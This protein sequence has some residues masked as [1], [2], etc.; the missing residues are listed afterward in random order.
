[1]KRFVTLLLCFNI[2]TV[3]SQDVKTF[4]IL[5]PLDMPSEHYGTCSY[6]ALGLSDGNFVFTQSYYTS[7]ANGANSKDIG[8]TF[9]K[10]SPQAEVIDTLFYEF[11]NNKSIDYPNNKLI[12]NPYNENENI[13]TYFSY[14]DTCYYNAVFFDNDLNITDEVR[15][16]FL[17]E[18]FGKG[19]LSGLN[20]D[21]NFL[22][23]WSVS[24]AEHW[25]LE[26]DIY[27]EVKKRSPKLIV[28]DDYGGFVNF[29]SF[30]T[31]DE[32]NKQ[33]G[34][35]NDEIDDYGMEHELYIILDENLNI[36]Y[37]KSLSGYEGYQYF[38]HY[39]SVAKLDDG[40]FVVMGV[41]RHGPEEDAL[42]LCKVD[43]DFNIIET[44]ILRLESNTEQKFLR[45]DVEA[46]NLVRCKDGG[47]YCI[48]S[49]SR[50]H[51]FQERD[52]YVARVDKDLNIMWDRCVKTG[53]KAFGELK[54]ADVLEN[55]ALVLTG[56]VMGYDNPTIDGVQLKTS[57][58]ILHDNGTS[59]SEN[60]YDIR[61]Y[62]FYPN[63]VRDKINIRFSPDVNCKKIDVYSMDGRLCH[64]QNFNMQT[65][66]IDNLNSGIYVMNITL[67]NGT[68][69][70]DRIVVY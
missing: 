18:G 60:I 7:D 22:Y 51:I 25:A 42:R 59:V 50:H 11:E 34:F 30:F 49:E 55:G 68:T 45:V 37:D 3:F 32:E 21:N 41:F 38:C 64:T 48:W 9:V 16:P 40:N 15:K 19:H 52:V 20:K 66:N 31:Y 61:P 43:K 26:A 69:Y 4:D 70:T 24:A 57:V 65:I 8:V 36:A 12:R 46:R 54:G 14:S 13:Y 63:P 62:S 5:F 35:A 1:M 23:F 47:F 39:T 6:H 44:S 10:M 17:A 29:Y 56:N 27:G 67:D 33:Y 28:G 58:I 53:L 2:V